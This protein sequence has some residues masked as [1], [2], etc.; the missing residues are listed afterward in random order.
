MKSYSEPIQVQA[1]GGRPRSLRWRHRTARVTDLLDFW[2]L[3]TR[4]W[5]KEEKRCYYLLATTLGDMEV[6]RRNGQWVLSRL[7]D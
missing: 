3:Q 7:L 5:E 2:I 6:Y 4:W 1:E